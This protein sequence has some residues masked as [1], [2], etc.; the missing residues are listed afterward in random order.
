MTWLFETDEAGLVWV[1]AHESYPGFSAAL[2]DSLGSLSPRGETP[3]LSTYWIDRALTWLASNEDGDQRVEV[4]SGNATALEQEGQV[5]QAVALYETFEPE[6][7]PT[8]EVVLGLLAWRRAIIDRIE[9]EGAEVP[10]T[11]LGGVVGMRAPPI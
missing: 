2:A 10:T 7:L 6:S 3:S 8:G 5:V 11:D 4:S 9:T 1:A